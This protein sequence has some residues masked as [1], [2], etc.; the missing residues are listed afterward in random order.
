MKMA[1]YQ[2]E[3]E[4][5]TQALDFIK[6]N[7]GCKVSDV[8]KA[9]SVSRPVVATIVKSLGELGLVEKKYGKG[10]AT[11]LY[12][13]AKGEEFLK[14]KEHFPAAANGAQA[15]QEQSSAP[16]TEPAAP[17]VVQPSEALV[18]ATVPTDVQQPQDVGSN[19]LRPET[20]SNA[21]SPLQAGSEPRPKTERKGFLAWL[22]SLF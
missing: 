13:T 21:P 4:K 8:Q 9:I 14:Q 5:S 19:D 11:A 12:I 6:Q 1:E 7:P 2:V 3:G 10:R 22:R 16:S 20:A 17:Q 15:M 18:P